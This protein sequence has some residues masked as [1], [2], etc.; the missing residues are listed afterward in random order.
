MLMFLQQGICGRH[1]I[2]KE[3]VSFRFEGPRDVRSE[4]F[5]YVRTGCF[6]DNVLA[7]GCDEM[8]GGIDGSSILQ[9]VGLKH[10]ID[11]LLL[12]QLEGV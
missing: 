1:T 2:S 11:F 4:C 12:K 9:G 10:I 3:H 5:K 6:D 7:E 8:L